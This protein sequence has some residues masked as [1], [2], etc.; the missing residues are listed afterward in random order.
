M[1]LEFNADKLGEIQS[2]LFPPSFLNLDE[3][4]G[5]ARVVSIVAG[6]IELGHC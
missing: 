2:T 6:L 5:Q 3:L 1:G 4:N